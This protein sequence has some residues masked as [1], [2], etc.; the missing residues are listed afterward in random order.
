MV[1]SVKFVRVIKISD[2]KRLLNSVGKSSFVENYEGY[3]GLFLKGKGLSSDDKKEFANKLYERNPDAS[4]FQAQ[5]TRV[6]CAINIFKNGWEQEALKDIVSST[7]KRVS[8]EIIN[9]AKELLK[10]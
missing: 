9:K 7:S 2:Y 6:S 10:V 5:L 8:P 3:R 1:E 4:S